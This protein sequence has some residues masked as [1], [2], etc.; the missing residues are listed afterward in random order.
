[1]LWRPT[2]PCLGTTEPLTLTLDRPFDR[3]LLT[4]D[5]R[6]IVGA[7][8]SVEGTIGIGHGEGEWRFTPDTPWNHENLL[9]RVNASLEDVA[10]N[11][12]RDLLDHKENATASDVSITEFPIILNNC[13]E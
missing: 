4:K 11:N 1:M 5:V 2:S 8:Q 6:V 9:V 13:P 12:F 10:G 7:G 3:H